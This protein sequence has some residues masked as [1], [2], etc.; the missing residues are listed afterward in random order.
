MIG[1]AIISKKYK[2]RAQSSLCLIETLFRGHAYLIKTV[3][4][5]HTHAHTHTHTCTKLPSS[6]TCFVQ[7]FIVIANLS[8]AEVAILFRRTDGHVKCWY[9]NPRVSAVFSFP[10]LKSTETFVIKVSA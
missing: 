4:P 2:I 8:S 10:R 5:T 1:I 3:N 7:E 9:N 6:Y